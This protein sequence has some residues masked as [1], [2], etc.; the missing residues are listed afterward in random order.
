MQEQPMP[1]EPTGETP[2]E[3]PQQQSG[4]KKTASPE[5]NEIVERF[6][7][8]AMMIASGEN[9]DKMLAMAKSAKGDSAQGVGRAIFFV[10]DAVRKGLTKKG[11]EIPSELWLAK[12]GLLDQ[13]SKIVSILLDSAGVKMDAE[14]VQQGMS[15]AAETMASNFDVENGREP[16]K[17]EGQGEPTDEEVMQLMQ[18]MQGQG[19]GQP[20][21]GGMPP[22]GMPPQGG[23]PPQQA[24]Q[25]APQGGLLEQGRMQ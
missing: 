24:P 15:L 22:Q 10:M 13:T 7:T 23:Q 21:Q 5:D 25:Q 1:Q 16:M 17:P 9:Y 2:Q 4:E 8:N 14:S 12:N 11:V 6:V 3:A 18:Q 19:G 20:P